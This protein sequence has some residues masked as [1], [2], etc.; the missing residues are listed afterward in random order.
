MENNHDGGLCTCDENHLVAWFHGVPNLSCEAASGDVVVGDHTIEI[1]HKWG[2]IKEEAEIEFKCGKLS[3][4]V[5]L[6]RFESNCDWKDYADFSDYNDYEA[7]LKLCE[8]NGEDFD[9]IIYEAFDTWD[10]RWVHE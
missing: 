7:M 6:M 9:D 2:S 8:E 1:K 4:T 10:L 3:V 5:R